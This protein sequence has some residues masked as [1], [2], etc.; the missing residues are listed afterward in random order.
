MQ[1]RKDVKQVV[2]IGCLIEF[3]ILTKSEYDAIILFSIF[4]NLLQFVAFA[5]RIKGGIQGNIKD[6]GGRPVAGIVL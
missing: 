5:S 1:V 3:L 4:V 2:R 6:D